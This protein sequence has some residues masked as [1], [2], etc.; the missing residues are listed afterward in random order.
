M[1][2]QARPFA[3]VTGASSGIGFELAKCCADKGFNL[4]VVADEPNIEQ[5]A[6]TLRANGISV[7]AL[8][9]DL[10]TKEGVD[11]LLAM[12]NGREVTALIANAGHGLGKA[13]L[14]QRWEDIRHVID[15]NV[16]GTLYLVHS[17]GREMR[18]LGRGK[19]LIVGSIA[20]FMPGTYQAVYNG[21]KAMIDSFAVALRHEL[22]DSGIT[23]TCLQPGPTETAFFERADLMDTKVGT[24]EKQ[25]ADEVAKVGFEAMMRGDGD[26]IAGFKNKL[27]VAASRVM[28]AD[29]MAEQHT[30]MAKPGTA[31]H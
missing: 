26:V 8:Q 7:D 21:T 28:S 2:T 19:I 5:A 16:T 18:T 17:I 22:K 12:A 20:G 23:V 1:G 29:M 6:A 10:A 30:K 31:K 27:Q 25:P 4:L 24:D 13:F 11:K 14:D 15:T 9:A 3:I